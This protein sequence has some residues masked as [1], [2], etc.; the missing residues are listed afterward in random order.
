ILDI[1]MP[2]LAGFEVLE[3]LEPPLPQVIF[4]TAFD[5]FALDAFEASAVDYLLKPYDAARFIKALDRAFAMRGSGKNG[6]LKALLSRVAKT[7]LERL[8]VKSEDCWIPVPLRTVTRFSADG[9]QVKVHSESGVHSVRTSLVE[10]E[11]RLDPRRFMLV[12]RGEIVAL[13]AVMHLEPWD[14]GDGLLVLKDGSKVVLSRTYR[15]AFVER[16]GLEG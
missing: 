13:D 12:H 16:W 14:H 11:R 5:R 6:E 2:G 8:L 7:P 9:K 15:A 3:A 10:L 4:S 1:Q